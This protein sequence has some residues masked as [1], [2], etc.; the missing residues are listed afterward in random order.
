MGTLVPQINNVKKQMENFTAVLEDL[1]TKAK[2]VNGDEQK[3]K[4]SLIFWRILLESENLPDR[5]APKRR[6]TK[7]DL[8][9]PGKFSED[10]ECFCPDLKLETF[11]AEP[12]VY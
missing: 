6:M 2:A 12:C 1:E 7:C 9:F 11:V 10:C 4:V 8:E 3:R 5:C